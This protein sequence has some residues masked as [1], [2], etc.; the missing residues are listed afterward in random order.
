MAEAKSSVW[1]GSMRRKRHYLFE[2]MTS[3]YGSRTTT[4]LRCSMVRLVKLNG[5]MARKAQSD[6]RCRTVTTPARWKYLHRLG[7]IHRGM[8]VLLVMIHVSSL[9][10]VMPSRRI[11]VRV[12]SF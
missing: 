7:F 5:L 9:N 4:S 11:R 10:L 12:V 1:I 3:L 2:P 6:Y 8:A